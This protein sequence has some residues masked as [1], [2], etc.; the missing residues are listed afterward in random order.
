MKRIINIFI[1]TLAVFIYGCNEQDYAPE[2]QTDIPVVEG[3]LQPGNV[4]TVNLSKMIPYISVGVDTT[5]M[6][7]AS[8]DVFIKHRDK[9]YLLEPVEDEPG[10]YVCLDSGLILT[11][12]DEYKLHFDYNLNTVSA[13]T[14]IPTKPKNTGLYPNVLQINPNDMRPGMTQNKVTVY[15]NNPDNDY[16]MIITEYLDSL[17]APINPY[18][19]PG[20]FDDYRKISTKPV[21]DF[22]YDLDTRRQLL[23][24]GHYR[25]I[26]YSVNEEYVNLYENISQSSLNLTEPLTNV[27]NGLGIFTGV[28]SDTLLLEVQKIWR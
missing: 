15:W 11:Q 26:I 4:I 7:I 8:T 24:F 1:L 2:N 22:S 3:Y 20:T 19:D 12:G 18:V 14:T 23:F 21:S 25:V 28:N 16:Y 13:V 6:V 5:N 10:K 27:K 9:D 17:Y